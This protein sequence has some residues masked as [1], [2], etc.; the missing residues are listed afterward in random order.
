M[1]VLHECILRHPVRV[2]TRLALG[3]QLSEL[4]AVFLVATVNFIRRLL[5]KDIFNLA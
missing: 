1:Y 2:V 4:R 5:F 3:P